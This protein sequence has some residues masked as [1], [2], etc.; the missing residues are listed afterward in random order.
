[1]AYSVWAFFLLSGT[2]LCDRNRNIRLLMVGLAGATKQIAL[3]AAPFLIIRLWQES[4]G[5]KLRN[6]LVGTATIVTGFIGPN[7]P[8]ILSSPSQWWAS[9][10]SPYLPGGA[11]EIHGGV[12]LAGI[13]LRVGISPPPLFFVALMGLF[14]DGSLYLVA[15]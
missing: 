15:T 3:I 2:G 5:S 1:W 13:L 4:P 6:T 10:I 11:V 14:G 12:G 8:F 7:I 9:T